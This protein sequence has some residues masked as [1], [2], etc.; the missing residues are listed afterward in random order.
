MALDDTTVWCARTEVGRRLFPRA[1]ERAGFS[2]L[3]PRAAFSLGGSAHVIVVGAASWSDP[4]LTALDRLAQDTRN[5]DVRVVVVDV[6]SWPLE[7]ILQAFPG[8]PSPKATP[9][10]L[11]YKRGALTYAGDG[12]EAILWL[13]ISAEKSKKFT[14]GRK[15]DYRWPP[16]ACP[17]P[18][19]LA[20]PPNEAAA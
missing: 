10:V 12:H 16:L 15:A 20:W 13:K 2:L 18:P 19:T 8:A 17:P 5:R 3:Q 9:F 6:D 14:A 4:D 7:D 1:V 11:Q